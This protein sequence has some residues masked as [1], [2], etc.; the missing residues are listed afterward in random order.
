MGIGSLSHLGVVVAVIAVMAVAWRFKQRSRGASPVAARPQSTSWTFLKAV[1]IAAL[2]SGA[3]LPV[4][5]TDGFA[6]IIHM[7]ST[8]ALTLLAALWLFR[9][10]GHPR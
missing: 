9:R 8:I 3:M 10:N 6:P 1:L 4:L 2:F 5:R 7:V